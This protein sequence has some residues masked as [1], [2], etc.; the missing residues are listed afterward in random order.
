MAEVA[1]VGAP[2]I[3]A[4]YPYAGGHQ[5]LNA[6]PLLDSGAAVLV[7]DQHLSGGSLG[8]WIVQLLGDRERLSQMAQASKAMAK[9]EAAD[10]IA[11]LILARISDAR[12]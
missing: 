3:A 8:G 1:T 12:S 6:Q 5:R 10:T 4:P 7:E 9:P 2:C 11:D